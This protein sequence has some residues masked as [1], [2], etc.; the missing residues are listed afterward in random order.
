M[1]QSIALLASVLFSETSYVS[2]MNIA[3]TPTAEMEAIA[4]NGEVDY[5]RSDYT[6]F[7]DNQFAPYYFS[8]LTHDFGSNLEG[9]CAF[10]AAEMLLTFYDTYWDDRVVDDS[11]I[12]KSTMP[13][14]ERDAF[15]RT[16]SPGAYADP[17]F[18]G[19]TKDFQ[20]YFD[21]MEDHRYESLHYQLVYIASLLTST[22]P[23]QG[24]SASLT[25]I[26]STIYYYLE[27]FQRFTPQQFSTTRRSAT[28][29]YN[30]RNTVKSNLQRGQPSIIRINIGK[31]EPGYHA[32]VAYDYDEDN[33]EIYVHT[34]WGYDEDNEDNYNQTTPLSKL[35]TDGKIYEFLTL[36]LN[37]DHTC[38]GNY[39]YLDDDGKLQG[40]CICGSYIP[41]SLEVRDYYLDNL[42]TF[43][44]SSLSGGA[45]FDEEW[46]W[47][48]VSF[49]SKYG[50]KVLD[51][52]TAYGNSLT[53][54]EEQYRSL[55]EYSGD[56]IYVRIRAESV[57]G[58]LGGGAY[59]T[60]HLTPPSDYSSMMQVLPSQWGFD[61]RY[62]FEN[63]G[64]K[65]TLTQIDGSTQFATRRLRCGFIENRYVVL[66]PRR[67][68]AGEAYLQI[69]PS[70][71]V[72]SL[73]Y[74][75][76]WWSASEYPETAKLLV[77]D[78]MGNW[79]EAVDLAES[80][81]PE[82]GTYPHRELLYFPSGI[83]GIRFEATAEAVGDRNK[84]RLCIDDL[85]FGFSRT[86]PEYVF[87]GY[88]ST[89]T[90]GR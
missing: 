86:A 29:L 40:S 9:S 90:R 78:Y 23:S 72:Y 47:Y 64:I 28:A 37:T 27:R 8:G 42:P 32:V 74:S 59:C 66:S 56:D 67:E 73:V 36:T 77:R 87:G 43:V 21:F 34:G 3:P 30:P 41:W 15:M 80:D 70:R 79:T 89:Y 31:E 2:S 83:T 46:P 17:I 84:G 35:S 63:E 54:T 81:L 82:G 65:T 24:F 5:S 57:L 51:S 76:L 1:F 33:D 16:E 69:Q 45:W 39:Q 10:V 49:T 4:S 20:S 55:V 60:L 88:R 14:S 52:I 22:I 11:Y 71:T 68:S 12:D 62:W 25:D 7:L 50:A 58:E 44:W 19:N 13:D 53:L 18:T 38:S 6:P 48:T 75:A 85:V 26:E 61:A